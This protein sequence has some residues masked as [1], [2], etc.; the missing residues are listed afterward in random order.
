MPARIRLRRFVL[1]SSLVVLACV[2][3]RGGW[4]VAALLGR[5][6]S[7]SKLEGQRLGDMLPFPA[8]D[9]DRIALLACRFAGA[10]GESVHV[11]VRV[12]G[13][14]WPLRWG[15]YAMAA[16]D[17]S[18]PSLDLE[19]ALESRKLTPTRAQIE[20]VMIDAIGGEGPSGLGDTL[21][22]CDVTPTDWP[23]DPAART[24]AAPPAPRS[25]TQDSSRRP[26][27]D[28]SPLATLRNLAVARYSCGSAPCQRRAS[29]LG[30]PTRVLGQAPSYRGVIVVAE[31]RMRR[32]QL[33]AKGLIQSATAEEWVGALM[34]ESGHALGFAG[35]VA[36]GDSILVRDETKLR[37]AGRRALAGQTVAARSLEAL[38]LVEPGERLGTR[39]VREQDVGWLHAIEELVRKRSLEGRNS[40]SLFAS[41]GDDEARLVWREPDGRQLGVR[42][43]Y[44]R[45]ELQKGAAVT[46]R[47]DRATRRQLEKA[48]FELD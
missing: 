21:T 1:A 28:A 34:H 14:Q 33:N 47:P 18:L 36:L 27:A 48:G 45:R 16:L 44:W 29:T 24:T 7:L 32:A 11:R 5:T 4:D 23:G 40:M 46:L 31:I 22:E 43:P 17:R 35:H 19:L 8:F 38:Y 10:E 6:P 15:E 30:L 26:S 20:I 41:V 13:S 9:G 3:P 39:R 37:A 12:R 25:L 2:S 42:F